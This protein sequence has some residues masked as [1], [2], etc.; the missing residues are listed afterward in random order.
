MAYENVFQTEIECSEELTPNEA[1]FAIGLMVMIVDGDI[2]NNEVEILEGF[3]LRKGLSVLEV[4]QARQKV[5]RIRYS[6]SEAALFNAVKKAIPEP[7]QIEATIDLAVKVALADN[8]VTSEEKSFVMELARALN[9][10]DEEFSRIVENAKKKFSSHQKS[11][12]KIDEILSLLPEGTVYEGFSVA[13][14]A[15]SFYN[16]KLRAPNGQL[17]ILNIDETED[18]KLDIDI[19]VAPPWMMS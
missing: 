4:N 14:N 5:L 12:D 10:N 19:E 6:E 7:K 11:L 18:K 16:I 1:M 9:V 3:L 8:K 15:Y 17:L 2:D 13:K